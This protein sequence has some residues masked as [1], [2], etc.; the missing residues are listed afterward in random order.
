MCYVGQSRETELRLQ[1]AETK[2][3]QAEMAAEEFAKEA[4]AARANF[5]E[6][7]KLLQDMGDK[8]KELEANIMQNNEVCLCRRPLTHR[9]CCS[10]IDQPLN[11]K[12]HDR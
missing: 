11:M 9:G 1:L 6:A 2:T 12:Y 7:S 10:R 3:K 4:Q 5:D 8:Y